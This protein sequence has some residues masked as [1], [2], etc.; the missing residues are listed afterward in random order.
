LYDDYHSLK[1]PGGLVLVDH[2]AS[3]I[4]NADA[5]DVRQ[6]PTRNSGALWCLLPRQSRVF[7]IEVFGSNCEHSPVRRSAV[8]GAAALSRWTPRQGKSP[9]M[10]GKISG[11]SWPLAVC[12]SGDGKCFVACADEKL[13]GF[14]ELEAIAGVPHGGASWCERRCDSRKSIEHFLATDEARRKVIPFPNQSRAR[15][16]AGAT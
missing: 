1:S 11:N 5:G 10:P 12:P 13:M 2:V 15:S 6:H 4:V 8:I 14:L 16:R 3:R 7:W 9:V